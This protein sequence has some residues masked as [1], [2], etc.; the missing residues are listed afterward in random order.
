MYGYFPKVL[1]YGYGYFIK[2]LGYGY[3]YFH[4]F[5]KCIR[6]RILDT[7]NVS[8]IRILSDTDTFLIGVTI[9]G[10]STIAITIAQVTYYCN[11]I[12]LT[13]VILQYYCDSY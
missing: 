3:G 5:M 9:E 7:Q 10:E 11:S 13:K 8:S 12:A 1:G 4:Y 2:V 6:I